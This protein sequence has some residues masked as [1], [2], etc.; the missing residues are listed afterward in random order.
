MLAPARKQ[1]FL[2]TRVRAGSFG[3]DCDDADMWT[4][5]AGALYFTIVFCAG[6]VVG[7]LR[8][9]WVAP[10]IGNRAA[11]LAEAPFM[12]VFT[13]IA[14]RCVIRYLAMPVTLSDRLVMGCLALGLMLIAEFVLALWLR[15]LSLRDISR[16]AIP[17]QDWFI[18][19][20][21]LVLPLCPC[22]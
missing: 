19:R 14:A 9:L 20:S 7:T 3:G 4:L 10:R 15:R 6:F 5:Q 16:A 12:L 13:A 17:F 18:A 1:V 2:Q 8:T 22:F 21:W 11:E